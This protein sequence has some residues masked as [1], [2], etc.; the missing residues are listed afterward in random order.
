MI[1][2]RTFR[3]S[4]AHT[5]Y[6]EEFKKVTK[7]ESEAPSLPTSISKLTSD[8]L[9]DLMLRYTAWREFTEDILNDSLVEFTVAKEQYDNAYQIEYLRADSKLKVKEKEALIDT[10]PTIHE[11]YLYLQEAELYHNLIL[12]K[13]ESFTNCLTIISREITRRQG[14]P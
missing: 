6:R 1:R 5:L 3:N 7:P 13:L 12:R 4:Q 8:K 10:L 9:S 2:K 11:K 14:M